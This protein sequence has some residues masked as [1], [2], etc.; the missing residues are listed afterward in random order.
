MFKTFPIDHYKRTAEMPISNSILPVSSSDL[1]IIGDFLY[2]SKLS[3]TI[4]RL[5]FKDWP[6]EATQRPLY[7]G[8][9]ESGFKDPSV[10]CL[11]VVDDDS[12]DIVGYLGLKRKRPANKEQ[13]TDAG[14]GGGKQNIPDGLNP[15]VLSAVSTAVTE[16][17]KEMEGTDHFGRVFSIYD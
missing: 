15:D 4:N 17:A 1:P 8:A 10:E 3:L 6:N 13:Y 14:N 11:K 16:I 2:S 5:L 7:A 12:R 9:V